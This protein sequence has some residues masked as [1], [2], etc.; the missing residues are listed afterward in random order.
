MAR[1][2]RRAGK[3]VYLLRIQARLQEGYDFCK[4]FSNSSIIFSV[5]IG[6]YFF[7]YLNNLD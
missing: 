3:I 2:F 5:V 7:I 6:L 4:V 1:A